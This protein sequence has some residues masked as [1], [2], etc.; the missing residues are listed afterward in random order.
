M[1]RLDLIISLLWMGALAAA[2]VV[3]ATL[4]WLRYRDAARYARHAARLASAT[5]PDQ[6]PAPVIPLRPRA[7]PASSWQPARPADPA[8]KEA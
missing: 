5:S 8:S 2:L 6:A 4:A 7:V 3:R 1:P